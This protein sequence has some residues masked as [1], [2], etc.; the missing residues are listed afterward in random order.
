MQA[1]R[2]LWKEAGDLESPLFNPEINSA[3]LFGDV[4]SISSVTLCG[5]CGAMT[6]FMRI[7]FFIASLHSFHT[8]HV[9]ESELMA[10]FLR[11]P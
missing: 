6:L 5:T 8:F 9:P 4:A 1:V 2:L 10:L 7:S 3:H 11:I